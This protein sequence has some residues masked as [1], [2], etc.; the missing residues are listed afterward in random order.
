MM[1]SMFKGLEMEILE[2]NA[3]NDLK[4]LSQWV[5]ARHSRNPVQLL[6]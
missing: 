1:E 4:R 6:L 2:L 3:W 5:T